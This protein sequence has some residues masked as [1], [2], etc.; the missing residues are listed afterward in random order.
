MTW[1]GNSFFLCSVTPGRHFPEAGVWDSLPWHCCGASGL[2]FGS[3]LGAS[4]LSLKTG[5]WGLRLLLFPTYMDA[6][7]VHLSPELGE[8]SAC[9]HSAHQLM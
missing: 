2:S 1:P 3:R 8:L 6:C 4:F 9:S 7:A 5:L